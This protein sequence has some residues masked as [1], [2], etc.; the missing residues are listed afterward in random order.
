M[1]PRLQRYDHPLASVE[2]FAAGLADIFLWE[3]FGRRTRLAERRFRFRGREYP[4]F[5]HRHNHTWMNER[6][7]EIPIAREALRGADPKHT[8]EVGNVLSHYLPVRHEVL[9]KFEIGSRVPVR[10]ID[11]LEFDPPCA[12]GRIVSISTVEHVGADER[13]RSPAKAVA[14]LHRIRELLRPGGSATVTWP[15]GYN[16]CL[17]RA[18]FEQPHRF[19]NV[20]ALVRV[21]AQNEWEESDLDRVRTFDYGRPYR[22]GNAVIVLSMAA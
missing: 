8:L 19:G 16:E 14:A 5:V 21:S 12:Y 22:C 4:Y 7:V 10:N 20:G 9:D 2:R 15:V 17:D 6:A 18:V 13:L 3:L 1:S 11:L